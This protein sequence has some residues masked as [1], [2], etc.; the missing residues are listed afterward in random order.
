LVC[1]DVMA[2]VRVA[3]H[4]SSPTVGLRPARRC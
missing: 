4:S 2:F 3:S 1:I